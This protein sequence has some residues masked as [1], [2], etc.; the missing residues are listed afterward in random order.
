MK[1]ILS[2]FI[3]A[4]IFV[5]TI[6]LFLIRI[7]LP[8]NQN[9]E[10]CSF[11][12]LDTNITI[13]VY[14]HVGNIDLIFDNTKE[15]IKSLENKL[16]KTIVYSDI[17]NINNNNDGDN[18]EI[19]LDT[20]F[21]FALSKDMY[22]ISDQKFD[23]SIGKLVDYWTKVREEEIKPNDNDINPLIKT[24]KHMDYE[25]YYNDG[26]LKSFDVLYDS[27]L[28]ENDI[29]DYIKHI[30]ELKQKDYK[31]Y[32]KVNN[33]NQSYD[34]GAIAKGYIADYI[35]YY[36]S[37]NGIKSAIINL[38]GNVLCIGDKLGKD[39]NIGIKKPFNENEI[40]DT[41]NAKD[42]SVTTSGIYERY[43]KFD[44]DDTIYHHI[45]DNTTGYP[46][47]NDLVSATIIT[48]LSVFGDSISTICI[49][50]GIDESSE[51]I[52]KIKSKYKIDCNIIYINKN[53]ELIYE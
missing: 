28:Y 6:V 17:Y 47:N 42:V 10:T 13:N 36:L 20:A 31:Y 44:N 26:E 45:I 37:K 24:T 15:L 2:K 41:V 30:Y 25:L 34:L 32:I 52:D 14:N 48:P 29:N 12:A 4:L 7:K 51:I 50:N 1:K 43:I 53:N 38:G 16:S 5:L 21:L 35:K 22:D 9:T 27:L 40:I 3:I 46:T 8:I 18:I 33:D 49:L 11:F 19:S 23:T 39:F